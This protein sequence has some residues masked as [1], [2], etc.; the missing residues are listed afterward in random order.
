MRRDLLWAV[1]LIAVALG[2]TV[3]VGRVQ[4]T[5]AS[6]FTGTTIAVGRFPEIDVSNH[7]F[8][9]NDARPSSK[10]V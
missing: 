1:I 6:G 2:A 5:P 3:Y 8:I 7:T 9:P 10:D 4:A